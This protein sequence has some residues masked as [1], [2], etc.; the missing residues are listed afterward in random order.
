M[1]GFGMFVADLPE[2]RAD[3]AR[4]DL[5]DILFIALAAVLCGAQSCSEMAE[6]GRAKEG[7]LRR[8]VALPHGVPSHDTFSRVFRLLDPEA[9]GAAFARF[10]AAFGAALPD[11]AVVAIDGKAMRR[12]HECGKAHMPPVMVTA[13]AA[14]TRLAL[15][16]VA[17]PDGNEVAGALAVLE[18]LDLTG[19]IVTTDALHCHR[20]MAKTIRAHGGDYALALKGNQSGLLRDARACLDAAGDV[21]QAETVTTG[22]GRRERRHAVVI[23]AGSMA[24]DHDFSG[25]TAIV[26][27]TC[28]R[29][30]S[31]PTERLYLLS[32]HLDPEQAIAVT[33]AHWDIE[34]GL[35]WS[36]DVVLAEDNLRCRKDNAPENLA[37]LNRLALNLVRAVDDPKTSIRRRFKKA[38]WNDDY[39]I[40]VISHMR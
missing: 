35:H 33:R 20:A 29:N 2:P 27:L 24:D 28:Q 34:N 36:L 32:R 39:L 25:L 37:V 22:H 26:R 31:P 5:G 11:A 7:L 19:T 16:C 10:T 8:F 1:T 38:A 30:D 23:D 40:S 13:W 17:S 18:M 4:H 3:N 12:A 15:A 14:D 21:A 6:F 9:F